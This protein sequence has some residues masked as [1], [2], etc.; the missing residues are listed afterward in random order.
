MNEWA[1]EMGTPERER[2]R[3]LAAVWLHDAL[4]DARLPDGTTHGAAAAD[5]AAQEGEAD[6]GVLDAVR[7]H[8]VGYA[9]WDNVGKMLYLADYLEPGRKGRRK[10]RARW[11]K[12]V[13]RERDAVLREV[14]ARQMQDQLHTGR[15]IH[16]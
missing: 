8:S 11:A 5:R 1:E 14:V 12:R 2:R 9:G 6:R 4:R 10:E 15:S 13:P 3:W 16:P 7:Y